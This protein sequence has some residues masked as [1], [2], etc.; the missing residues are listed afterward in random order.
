MTAADKLKLKELLSPLNF[1]TIA[2]NVYGHP[3]VDSNR[4]RN[5]I[6]RSGLKDKLVVMYCTRSFEDIGINR[7]AMAQLCCN[8]D[9]IEA[10]YQGFCSV[11]REAGKAV[12]QGDSAP[13]EQLF[14]LRLLLV[15]EFRRIV[16]KDPRLPAELLPEEWAGDTA[17]RLAGNIYRA[18]RDDAAKHFMQVCE[19]DGEPVE[20]MSDSYRGR[21]SRVC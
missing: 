2:S 4:L 6:T 16:L 11:F 7:E 19:Q 17:R 21:F 13:G 12:E 1:G 5:S 15:H 18:I 20:T 8:Y 9:E 14:L 3:N 10:A